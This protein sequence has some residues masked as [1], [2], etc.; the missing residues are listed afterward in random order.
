ME[1][2]DSGSR[3]VLVPVCADEALSRACAGGTVRVA[4]GPPAFR[5]GT[6]AKVTLAAS[7]EVTAVCTPRTESSE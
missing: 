1:T 7:L 3:P 5:S 6:V 2:R 4:F